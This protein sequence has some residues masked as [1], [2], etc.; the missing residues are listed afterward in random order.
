MNL[1]I[2]DEECEKE[3]KDIFLKLRNDG[4]G[5]TVVAHKKNGDIVKK[6]VKFL[7]SGKIRRCFCANC[8]D[9]SCDY[10]GRILIV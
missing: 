3:E 2:L 7:E 6:L 4:D 1:Y 10:E 5:I 9:F 8:G